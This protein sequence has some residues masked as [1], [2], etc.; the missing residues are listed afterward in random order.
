MPGHFWWACP[1]MP[2]LAWASIVPQAPLMEGG[3]E[4]KCRNEEKCVTG[5]ALETGE[6]GWIEPLGL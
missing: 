2:A 6:G 1:G 4:E 5:E 3:N